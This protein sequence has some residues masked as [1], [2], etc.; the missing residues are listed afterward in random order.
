VEILETSSNARSAE[1]ASQEKFSAAIAG[2]LAADRYRLT[3]LKTDVQD[4]VVNMTRFLV[5][6]R[7]C[8]PPTGH[9]RTSIMFNVRDAAGALHSALTPFR[10]YKIN[11]TKIES[12]P[13]KRKAWEYYFFVDCDGHLSDRK[14]ARAIAQLSLHCSFVK[15]LGSYPSVD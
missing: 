9:D 5:L 14:V 12:R 1:L 2:S 10:Q 13:S 11:M 7:K 4:N 3:I 15:V 8:G 6:G